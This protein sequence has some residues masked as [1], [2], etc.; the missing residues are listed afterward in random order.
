MEEEKKKIKNIKQ[1]LK[2]WGKKVAF[3]TIR[4]KKF[5]SVHY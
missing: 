3:K 5:Q 1:Y 2:I 4:K